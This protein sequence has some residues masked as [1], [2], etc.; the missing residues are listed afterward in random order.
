MIV[1][2]EKSVYIYMNVITQNVLLLNY[3]DGHTAI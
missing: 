2:I 3:M 1:I